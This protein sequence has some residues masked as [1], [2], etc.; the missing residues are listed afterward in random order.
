MFFD[1]RCKMRLAKDFN[2]SFQD[3][4]CVAGCRKSFIKDFL[5]QRM[6]QEILVRA[7]T[8]KRK[9]ST[10]CKITL[11]KKYSF[12]KVSA[13][14]LVNLNER[15]EVTHRIRKENGATAKAAR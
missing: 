9:T 6:F 4:Y 1:R 7:N 15:K 3:F 10:R 13:A 5:L 2:V 12:A 14:E 8:L 11:L